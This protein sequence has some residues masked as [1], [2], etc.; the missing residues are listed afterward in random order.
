MSI[1]RNQKQSG[2]DEWLCRLGERLRRRRLNRNLTQAEVAAQ[3]GVAQR[4]VRAIEGGASA[5]M[6]TWLSLLRTLGALDQ[7]DQFLPEPPIS[8]IELAKLKGKTRQRATGSRGSEPDQ[9]VAEDP[10]EGWTW[11]D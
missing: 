11:G 8:P 3:A 1:V 6:D 10:A 5:S 9:A 4:T 7:L 2:N